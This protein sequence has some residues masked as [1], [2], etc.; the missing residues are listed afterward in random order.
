MID[1]CIND[2]LEL[3]CNHSDEVTSNEE[4]FYEKANALI[5]L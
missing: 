1:K 4:N 2:D 3:S 5:K